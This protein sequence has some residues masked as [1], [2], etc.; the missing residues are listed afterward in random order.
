MSLVLLV[1][2][3]AATLSQSP[4]IVAR[5]NPIHAVREIGAVTG[6][7]ADCQRDEV[8]PRGTTAIRI[9]LDSVL[10]PRVKLR[11]RK[12][13]RLLTSGER[14]AGWT[15]ADVTIPVKA[16][17][18]TTD[19]VAVCFE[20]SAKDESV[21]LA[22]IPTGSARGSARGPGLVKIEY[23]EPGRRT[24]WS[25]ASSVAANMGVGHAWSGGWIVPF[26]TLVLLAI[27][28]IVSRSALR[29]GR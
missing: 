25:L 21:V 20:F 15:A 28:A 18:A 10:G 16:V 6:H 11:V 9:S 3:V 2:A 1:A 8:L 23:L 29:L 12:G 14:A 27:V 19:A 4:L 7:F 5:A 24:W 22:G 13:G 26:L 17:D